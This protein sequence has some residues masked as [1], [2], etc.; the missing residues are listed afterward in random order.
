MIDDYDSCTK[1]ELIEFNINNFGV[2]YEWYTDSPG[3]SKHQDHR[4]RRFETELPGPLW[5]GVLTSNHMEHE[6]DEAIKQELEYYKSKDK[7][8]MMWFTYPST[9]PTNMNEKLESQGFTNLVQSSPLMSIDLDKLPE[10]IDVPGLEIR[11]VRTEEEMHTFN[12]INGSRWDFGERFFKMVY[13]IECRYGFDEE[14]PRQMYLG[15]LD[16]EPVSSNFLIYDRYVVGLYKIATVPGYEKR[17]IGSAMT[18]MPLFDAL[19][20]GYK[21]AVLQSSAMGHKVYERLG[22]RE[23]SQMD[24]Y[25]HKWAENVKTL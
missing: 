16:G 22:F 12:E 19:D 5:N 17:G 8:G 6:V 3:A 2:L 4:V 14:S 25:M 1:E 18:L 24:G 21:V 20:R 9:Q 15:Y 10:P 23:D 11:S 13:D 7:F